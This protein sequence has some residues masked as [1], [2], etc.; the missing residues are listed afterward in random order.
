MQKELAY[1]AVGYEPGRKKL[2]RGADGGPLL[3]SGD[4]S[5]RTTSSGGSSSDESLDHQPSK[6]SPLKP[7]FNWANQ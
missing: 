5:S 1:A 7:P 3:E 4:S 2:R 6:E